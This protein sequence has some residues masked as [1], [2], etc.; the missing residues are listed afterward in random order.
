MCVGVKLYGWRKETKGKG[1]RFVAIGVVVRRNP[2]TG[3][4]NFERLFNVG[5]C[6]ADG[7]QRDEIA[8]L[9]R[10]IQEQMDKQKMTSSVEIGTENAVDAVE[11][12]LQEP[13][14]LPIHGTFPT[15][16]PEHLVDYFTVYISPPELYYRCDLTKKK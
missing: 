6:N 8:E 11:P 10:W 2:K 1:R 16:I 15:E 14:P 12:L 5:T 3:L 13:V 7:I 9:G 4:P